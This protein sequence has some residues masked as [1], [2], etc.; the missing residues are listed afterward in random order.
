MLRLLSPAKLNLGLWLLGKRPD[1]YHEVFTIYQAITLF[2]EIFIQ[3]GPL[4]VETSTG[5]PMEENLVYK[6][7][8]SM[9]ELLGEEL[10]FRVFIQKNI[11]EGAG[12]GGGS[13]NVAT[14]LRALNQLLGNPLS[15][16][17]LHEIASSVSSD[18]GFFLMGGSAIGRG[19][20]EVL[21]KIELP[22]M[23]FTLIYPG[24]KCS[25]AYVYSMVKED[26]LTENIEGDKIIDCLRAGDLSL[27][28]N[29]LGEL[30]GELYPEV[31]E[32]LRFLRGLGKVALVSGSGSSVFYVGETTQEV[33][34]ACKARGWKLYRVESYG[35]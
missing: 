4:N 22:S 25:T 2:D 13:S 17:E 15:L 16:R 14:V 23:V 27:L 5:I 12:L 28:Q 7:I 9:E 11:P 21:E 31:G 26:I 18:A 24:V 1:G 29:K 8:K 6:A 20:G 32:V 35:V 19:R 33:E 3:E 10:S 30:A 34:L